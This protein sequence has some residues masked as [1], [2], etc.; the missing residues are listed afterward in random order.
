LKTSKSVL[1][2]FITLLI[3]VS[4]IAGGCSSA[5]KKPL[6][7]MPSTPVP[8]TPVPNTPMTPDTTSP[9]PTYPTEVA[10]RAAT[11]AGKIMGVNKATVI[12]SG[13]IIY[14][15]L[16]LKA[17]LDKQKSAEIEKNVV[18]RV[19][20]M[21]SGYTVMVSSDVDTVTRIKNVAQGIAQG[22]PLSSF[23]TEIENIG[24]RL[25]PKIK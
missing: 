11:E 18:D 25:T 22:K 21:E 20:S 15:G 16:D 12:V 14:I 7:P 23:K 1:L 4:L 24:T 17:N 3:G 2:M 13:K 9:A 6:Q 10:N 8:S 5:A 19:K